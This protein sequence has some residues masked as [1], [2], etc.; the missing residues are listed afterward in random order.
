MTRDDA[1]VLRVELRDAVEFD[2]A[3]RN[4]N[5]PRGGKYAWIFKKMIPCNSNSPTETTRHHIIPNNILEDAVLDYGISEPGIT[6]AE[7]GKRRETLRASLQNFV[8]QESMRSIIESELDDNGQL[9]HQE[10]VGPFLHAAYSNNP[11]NLVRGPKAELRAN[12]PGSKHDEE[13]GNLQT[14]EHQAAVNQ[15]YDAPSTEKIDRFGNLPATIPVDWSIPP[16]EENYVANQPAGTTGRE[17]STL[18]GYQLS[19]TPPSVVTATV[20]IGVQNSR[21]RNH[22]RGMATQNFI[23]TGFELGTY[24]VLLVP[25]VLTAEGAQ[26]SGVYVHTDGLH[27]DEIKWFEDMD[28]GRDRVLIPTLKTSS[29]AEDIDNGVQVMYVKH[30]PNDEVGHAYYMESNGQFSEAPS[31]GYD[32]AFAAFSKILESNGISKCVGDLRVEAADLIESNSASFLKVLSAENWIRKTNPDSANKLLFTA[33]L[34]RDAQGI[35]RVEPDDAVEF[36]KA[37]REQNYP[38]GGK[39]ARIFKK[40][41]P[42]NPNSPT[43]T[44]RHHIIPNNILEDRVRDYGISEPGIT[45]AEVGKRRETLRASLQNFVNQESMR[46]IIESQLDDKGQL[47]H[48][49]DVGPF[50]HAAYSNNPNNL[51]RGPEAK[52]RAN[53]PGSEHDK[54][55]GN[56]QTHEH[57]AAVNQFYD[58]PSTEK[59]DRFGNLPATIPVDWS[60]PPG[61]E[62]YVANQGSLDNRHGMMKDFNRKNHLRGMA[63][64]NFIKTGFEQ[65]TYSVL[66]VPRV[67]TAEGAQRSGV[68]VHTDG[69]HLDEIKWFEDMDWGRD[70]VLIPT[71]KTSSFADWQDAEPCYPDATVTTV[72]QVSFREALKLMTVDIWCNMEYFLANRDEMEKDLG[73]KL[74]NLDLDDK[75]LLKQLEDELFYKQSVKIFGREEGDDEKSA[76]TFTDFR[77]LFFDG[78]ERFGTARHGKHYVVFFHVTG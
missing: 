68:Y 62:N 20:E 71:L 15:F 39:Y 51:V 53:D 4:R 74:P 25:R 21:R 47:K 48:Q 19:P 49:A 30:G 31:A 50:L 38:R 60:I 36:D 54:E 29:F 64:Q 77:H 22:L 1:G 6:A 37:I 35:L 33:G 9:K 34:K 43:E 24:S 46:S 72:E 23:K 56:L 12:D 57:Q 73:R 40:K 78:N 52:L 13:I 17:N 45:A 3:I 42:C 66:L 69:L 10:D 75:D 70:R 14:H 16:G 28:W 26:R 67:L 58:A 76:V 65:G 44:T 55:I 63:T 5:Y 41:I 18:R 61:E 8:N 7:A 11:N 2:D 27:L 32:S 59:I